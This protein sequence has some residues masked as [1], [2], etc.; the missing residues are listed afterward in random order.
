M[1][2]ADAE[3]GELVGS[4]VARAASCALT[5][6][7]PSSPMAASDGR[8]VL[9]Y[10]HSELTESRADGADLGTLS[11]TQQRSRQQFLRSQ[12]GELN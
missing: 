10:V 12:A 4:P 2:V 3:L 7:S 5:S 1:E 8:L 9:D 6:G 11:G